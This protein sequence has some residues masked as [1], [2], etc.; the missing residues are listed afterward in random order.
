MPDLELDTILS[1]LRAGINA[2]IAAVA[3]GLDPIELVALRV[4]LL[5]VRLDAVAQ[6]AAGDPDVKLQTD[7]AVAYR[8]AEYLDATFPEAAAA[9]EAAEQEAAAAERPVA[10]VTIPC[11]ECGQDIATA[12]YDAH[13]A[14]AHDDDDNL[15]EGL[16]EPTPAPADA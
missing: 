13:M 3:D 10:P 12:D 1:D 2:R 5:E 16:D 7:L 8:T 11:P 4:Q 14:D 6:Q 15:P 9:G